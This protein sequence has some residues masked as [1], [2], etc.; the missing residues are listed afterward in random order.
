MTDS[1]WIAPIS[2][3]LLPLLVVWIVFIGSAEMIHTVRQRRQSVVADDDRWEDVGTDAERLHARTR[4]VRTGR[5]VRLAGIALLAW[6]GYLTARS[7]PATAAVAVAVGVLVLIRL[8]RPLLSFLTAVVLALLL[9]V[10]IHSET[11]SAMF[12]LA[13]AAWVFVVGNRAVHRRYPSYRRGVDQP[14]LDDWL[15]VSDLRWSRRRIAA[16]GVSALVTL[17]SLLVLAFYAA[18]KWLAIASITD[19]QAARRLWLGDVPGWSDAVRVL[20]E[21]PFG[22][23][24]VFLI[25]SGGLVFLGNEVALGLWAPDA[26]E[27]VSP[28][29]A[30]TIVYLRNFDDDKTTLRAGSYTRIPFL[31]VLFDV[32]VP[33][34]RRRFEQVL[35]SLLRRIGPVI[36]AADPRTA[37][38]ERGALK[39]ALAHDAWRDEV[40]RW[41][42]LAQAVVVSATPSQIHDGLRDELKLLSEEL[43]HERIVLVLGP[44]TPEEVADRFARF[45]QAFPPG[46]KLVDDLDERAVNGTLVMVRVPGHGWDCWG[47]AHR[48]EAAYAE[49]LD[50]AME[51]GERVWAAPRPVLRRIPA[52]API[53][54]SPADEPLRVAPATR[55]VVHDNRRATSLAPPSAA[56]DDQFAYV[57]SLAWLPA[58]VAENEIRL[59]PRGIEPVS[60]P[61]PP[62]TLPS[63]VRLPAL[64][65]LRPAAATDHPIRAHLWPR[66]AAD[67]SPLLEPDERILAHWRTPRS[68]AYWVKDDMT[69]VYP[70]FHYVPEPL[71]SNVEWFA[72]DRR[73]MLVT[74]GRARNRAGA[75]HIRYDWV[76][77]LVAERYQETSDAKPDTLTTRVIAGDPAGQRLALGITP[78]RA[79]LSLA[80]TILGAVRYGLTEAGRSLGEPRV[81]VSDNG[82]EGKLTWT[83]RPV[84]GSGPWIPDELV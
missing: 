73:L 14:T 42:E 37:R 17:G 19:A 20:A 55:I 4:R 34:R 10:H 50:R 22:T 63:P 65:V 60:V 15:P 52:A 74:R 83:F 39:V 69:G 71:A 2:A 68:A 61:V 53:V 59:S 8:A 46:S 70:D 24:E 76:C 29:A 72:T 3:V 9:A 84:D 57:R 66:L 5:V 62:A 23:A 36:G 6:Y 81:R 38:R 82:K 35:A 33:I 56:P 47:A 32:L 26:W 40:R 16:L 49:A 12:L 77:G 31:Q 54:P 25:V 1:I 30:N 51:Y 48:T 78:H 80:E 58:N 13:V 79:D 27:I 11:W 7:I 18:A 64:A 28:E 43:S 44:G 41:C 67:L 75:L 21:A 45:R